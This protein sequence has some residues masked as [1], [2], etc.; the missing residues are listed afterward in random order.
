MTKT[1]KQ[2]VVKKLTKEE[3]FEIVK[4]DYAYIGSTISSNQEQLRLNIK[5]YINVGIDYYKNVSHLGDKNKRQALVLR[6]IK[7]LKFKLSIFQ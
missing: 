4:S 5:R 6:G 2:N 7:V 1:K 3:I